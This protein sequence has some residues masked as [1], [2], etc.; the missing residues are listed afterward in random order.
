[1]SHHT[2]QNKLRLTPLLAAAVMTVSAVCTSLPAKTVRADKYDEQI[3]ALEQKIANEAERKNAANEISKQQVKTVDDLVAQL[4]NLQAIVGRTSQQKAETEDSL[5]KIEVEISDKRAELSE[6]YRK[7]YIEDSSLSMLEMLASSRNLSDFMSRQEY[8]QRIK[9]QVSKKVDELESKQNLAKQKKDE[10]SRIL[11]EQSGQ[12]QVI[13]QKKQTAAKD[14]GVS[15]Q[16]ISSLSG[17]ISQKTTEIAA[18]REEQAAANSSLLAALAPIPQPV[19]PAPSPAPSSQPAAPP[20]GGSAPAPS[21]APTPPPANYPTR[22]GMIVVYPPGV[23]GGGYPGRWANVPQDSV[24]DS[25]GMYNRECVSYTAFKVWQSGRHM[26]YWGGRGNAKQWPYNG[27]PYD[28]NPRRGD[29]AISLAGYYG[30]AM[31]VEDVYPNGLIKVSQYNF[32][33]RGEY[34]EM[35]ISKNG[36]LFVHF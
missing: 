3:K 5:S 25:W 32:Y 12:Q 13:D 2:R 36:L 4:A 11:A 24:V 30:H 26:P 21:P 31:Y 14:L 33:V 28:S 29:V 23:S 1:M 15:Q 20:S 9:R 35:I 27:K 22:P 18:L 10:I 16:E 19:A 34:S 7:L 8:R 17:S 6:Q